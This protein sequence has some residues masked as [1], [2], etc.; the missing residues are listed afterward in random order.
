MTRLPSKKFPCEAEYF[1]TSSQISCLPPSLSSLCSEGRM[2]LTLLGSLHAV[3]P[4]LYPSFL[5]FPPPSSAW[6]Q[7]RGEKG[8]RSRKAISTPWTR[9]R[10]AY[11]L[12]LLSWRKGHASFSEQ[13]ISPFSYCTPKSVTFLPLSYFPPAEEKPCA[14]SVRTF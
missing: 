5:L 10:H 3:L 2:S 8:A 4:P 9:R 14:K 11:F 1:C 13:H 12:L 7:K 6:L